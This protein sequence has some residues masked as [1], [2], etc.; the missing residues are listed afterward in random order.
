MDST[1][2]DTLER[3]IL[4]F[5]ENTV[6]VLLSGI[7]QRVR[8]VLVRGGVLRHLSSRDDVAG[9]HLAVRRVVSGDAAKSLKDRLESDAAGEEQ[10]QGQDHNRGGGIGPRSAA[11]AAV[12]RCCGGL[13]VRRPRLYHK[14]APAE[15]EADAESSAQPRPPAGTST[16]EAV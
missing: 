4:L 16:G 11:A 7:D 6:P 14:S 1:G 9:V 2:V 10:G 15:A 8:R 13:A 5:H 12:A 3:V